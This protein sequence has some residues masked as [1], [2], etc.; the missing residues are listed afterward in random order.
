[1]TAPVAVSIAES[2][3]VN[4][5]VMLLGAAVA[6]PCAFLPPI[7]HKNN[8]IIME[9]GG[10]RFGDYWLIGSPLETIV[11]IISIPLLLIF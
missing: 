6:T 5:N 9:P 10:D 8:A 3:Q 1:M 4:P 7:G 11:L 2:L